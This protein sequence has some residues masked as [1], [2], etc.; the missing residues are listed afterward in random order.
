MFQDNDVQ[1]I[2]EM[3]NFGQINFRACTALSYLLSQRKLFL[4]IK[5][6]GQR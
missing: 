5:F 6:Q 2:L 1:F 4:V 3:N